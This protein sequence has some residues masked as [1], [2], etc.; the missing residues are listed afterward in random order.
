MPKSKPFAK[1]ARQREAV[2]L[3]IE[4][5]YSLLL[6]GARSG[7]TFIKWD[8]Y[9]R[10]AI[11][12][13]SRHLE[14][15]RTFESIK[16]SIWFDTLPKL[17]EKAFP[18]FKEGVHY[19]LS[20]SDF[21][22]QF[23]N[24]STIWLAG[25]D[26]QRRMDRILGTEYSTI[27]LNECNELTYEQRETLLTRLAENSGLPL[28]VWEDC[29][30]PSKKHWI[31]KLYI[32]GVHPEEGKPLTEKARLDHGYIFMNPED[33]R[34][35]LPDAYF[36]VLDGLSSKKRK[37]FRDGLFTDDT[38]GSLWSDDLIYECQLKDGEIPEWIEDAPLTVVSLD[39]NVAEN[40]KRGTTFNADEVGIVVGCKDSPV[41]NPEGKAVVVAD[42]SGKYSAPQWAK[43]AVWAYQH[44]RANC[45]VAEKNN[46]GELVRMALRAEDSTVPVVLVH[47]SKGKY[48]R[49]EP[50]VTLYENGKVTHLSGMDKLEDE[51]TEWVPGISDY[52][53]NRLD[54]LVWLLTYL[55][56]KTGS[57]KNRRSVPPRQF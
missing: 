38:E 21:F 4:K 40:Q 42:Y 19:K 24:G 45:I 41:R 29:N 48:A 11:R 12:R 37:R 28:K 46:G 18:Q 33:N 55:F 9:F 16:K 52:S 5:T 20:R 50:T 23:R 2:A 34:E 49:A 27:G 7:K 30:P 43:K 44:H 8:S 54:A 35:N 32:D 17:L 14:V 56:L 15:R 26:D 57:N 25:M 36:D 31:H 47:A 39:P 3:M 6:G 53:P 13:K 10:R 1:T 51:M 22:V